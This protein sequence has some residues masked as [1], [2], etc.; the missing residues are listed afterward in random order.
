[1]IPMERLWYTHDVAGCRMAV[2]EVG[3]ETGVFVLERGDAPAQAVLDRNARSKAKRIADETKE[4]LAEVMN[5]VDRVC[6]VT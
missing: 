1:M 6:N 2:E 4:E 3:W 5:R